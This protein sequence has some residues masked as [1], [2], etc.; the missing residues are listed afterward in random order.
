MSRRRASFTAV[1]FGPG[2]VPEPLRGVVA[3][4]LQPHQEGEHQAPALH[5]VDLLEPVA[6]VLHR[7]LVERRLLAAQWTE[8]L[9]LGLVRQVGDDALVGLQA[10]QDV[11]AH[12]IAQRRVGGVRPVGEALDEVGE[13]LGRPEQARIDEV[14]DRPQVAEAVLDRRAG[15]RDAGIGLER[16]DRLGL[17]GRRVLD[18]LRLVDDGQAPAGGTEPGHARQGPVAGDDEIGTGEV[19]RGIRLQLL[20][21]HGR[22]VGDKRLQARR[23][24]CDLRGPVGEQRGRRDEQARP[25]LIAGFTFQHQQQR[26]HLDGLAEAHVVGEA[27]AE[28]EPGKQI[29]PLHAHHL[30]GPES[31]LE[32]W[33]GIDAG[34]PVGPAQAL[35]GLLEPW[36]G[37]CLAPC[38]ASRSGSSVTRAVG[39]RQQPHGL[40]ERQAFIG[41]APLDRLEP[42]QR[43]AEAIMVDLDPLTADVGKTFRLRQQ[44]S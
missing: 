1:G 38:H 31:G 13:L 22:G 33:A 7:L 18:R 34:E 16:L 35:E 41:R 37:D 8:G 15:Q 5:A 11:G 44:P 2:A 20:G 27:G 14:E 21:R 9:H 39:A 29:E 4:L 40:A 28:P 3:D 42:L 24:P 6:Q 26:Q 43:A 23:E 32:R 25:R 36:P 17:L 30:I 12:Q 19:L 10:A